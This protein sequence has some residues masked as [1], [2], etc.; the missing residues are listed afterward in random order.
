MLYYFLLIMM[1]NIYIYIGLKKK[2]SKYLV[3]NNIICKKDKENL[4]FGKIF[5]ID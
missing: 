5:M 1:G 4:M 3:D 2:K